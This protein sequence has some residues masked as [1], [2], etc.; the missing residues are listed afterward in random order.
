MAVELGIEEGGDVE[1]KGL[2][3]IGEIELDLE[4]GGV[5]KDEG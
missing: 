3:C 2:N 5:E 4:Y 1:R